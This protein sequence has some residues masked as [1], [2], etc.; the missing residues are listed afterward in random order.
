MLNYGKRRNS[1]YQRRKSVVKVTVPFN[2]KKRK[3]VDS[4]SEN[5]TVVQPTS[6]TNSIESSNSGSSNET[7]S[8]SNNS[9]YQQ[10]NPQLSL[11]DLQSNGDNRHQNTTTTT[12]TTTSSNNTNNLYHSIYNSTC[13]EPQQNQILE[14]FSNSSTAL[15]NS[16]TKKHKTTEDHGQAPQLIS[17]LSNSIQLQP[18]PNQLQPSVHI[19]RDIIATEQVTTTTQRI[20]GRCQVTKE[21]KERVEI[22]RMILLE[23]INN[24]SPTLKKYVRELSK[25]FITEVAKLP[26]PKS[27]SKNSPHQPPPQQTPSK[28][29]P[30]Q[31]NIK[32]L[33]LQV[34]IKTLQSLIE[35]WKM[36]EQQW[37]KILV[38]YSSNGKENII[39]ATPSRSRIP[40]SVIKNN[41][42]HHHH[43]N[44]NN[45]QNNNNNNNNATLTSSIQSTNSEM[46]IYKEDSRITEIKDRLS[47]L[48]IQMDEVKPRIKQIEQTSNEIEQY[49]S[50][51]SNHYKK[52]TFKEL[53]DIN[54]PKKLIK[55]LISNSSVPI[56]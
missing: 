40:G 44:N 26:I 6:P 36:E 18:P 13:T 23:T 32:N 42:N 27:R 31:P 24:T 4:D 9:I 54:N 49:Y 21:A 52:S 37:K 41:N 51:I 3:D 17:S 53:Q 29:V 50:E 46:I 25:A 5:G 11:S 30:Y 33:E 43:N 39:L 20:T 14:Q 47:K 34:R 15:T 19:T 7:S 48:S 35:K 28:P 12:T 38:E 16:K 22:L 10:R 45:N 1:S 8:S 56:D 55:N 2:F